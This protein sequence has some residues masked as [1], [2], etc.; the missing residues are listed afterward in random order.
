MSATS[1]GNPAVSDNLRILIVEDVAVDAEVAAC[2]E[3]LVG[4]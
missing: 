2:G 4:M 1:A 3:S